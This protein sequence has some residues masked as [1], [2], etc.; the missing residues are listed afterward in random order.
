ME[1]KLPEHQKLANHLMQELSHTNNDSLKPKAT[2]IRLG[3]SGAPGVGKSTLIE[4]FGMYLVRDQRKR[5]AVLVEN[6]RNAHYH[7]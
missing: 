1:S 3:F 6:D 5:L 2:T 7:T 4:T